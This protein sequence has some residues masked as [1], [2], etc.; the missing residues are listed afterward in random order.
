MPALPGMYSDAA[1]AEFAA[2]TAAGI[3]ESP[4]INSTQNFRSLNIRTASNHVDFFYGDVVGNVAGKVMTRTDSNRERLHKTS[5]SPKLPKSITTLCQQQGK[6]T[7]QALT[8]RR[9]SGLEGPHR[10]TLLS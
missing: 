6:Q 8:R 3:A 7:R 9:R 10:T 2:A 4:L 5:T 1:S